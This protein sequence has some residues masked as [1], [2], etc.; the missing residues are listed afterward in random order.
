MRMAEVISD[1]L[2]QGEDLV[3]VRVLGKSGSAPSSAEVQMV[4]RA[5][6][7]SLGTIGGG[8]VEA[9]AQAKAPEIFANRAAEELAFDLTSP[10][11]RGSD[12][13]CGGRVRLLLDFIE[14][15]SA[16]AELFR[17]VRDA[18][19]AGSRR[20]LLAWLG[21]ESAPHATRYCS[22]RQDG[23]T[24]GECPLTAEQA[25]S[26]AE[27][28]RYSVYPLIETIGGERFVV[29]RCFVPS[30]LYLVGAGHVAQSVATV[31]DIAG[32]RTVVLDD[33]WDYATAER[34]P[35]AD[36]IEVLGS[37]EHSFGSFG[38]NGDSYIVIV[39]RSHQYDKIALAEALRTGAR[40]IGMIGSRTK[41][42]KIYRALREDGFSAEDFARVH[43]PIGLDIGGDS[44]GE[45][46]V[47]IVAELVQVRAQAVRS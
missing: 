22:I 27:K 18:L 45:I 47:S 5:D 43:S 46:A 37:F 4:V 29:E 40:Y 42:D 7:S 14:A 34:F 8:R 12:M 23:T 17:E 16:H 31:A 3:Y 13:I 20:F 19:R 41:R 24:A 44:P 21:S 26:L 2:R 36:A 28:A 1:L 30:T 38:V 15:T 11:A 10:D 39:T 25:A 6:G 35:R 9:T 32:F 33:R